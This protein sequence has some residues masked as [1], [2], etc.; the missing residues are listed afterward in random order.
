MPFDV[1]FERR[2]MGTNAANCNYDCN[3]GEGIQ[4]DRYAG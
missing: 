1:R 2:R 4:V 3:H